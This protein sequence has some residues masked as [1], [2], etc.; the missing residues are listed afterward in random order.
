MALQAKSHVP[1]PAHVVPLSFSHHLTPSVHAC[2]RH[3]SAHTLLF[4]L[5]PVSTFCVDKQ[6]WHQWA[7]LVALPTATPAVLVVQAPL[8]HQPPLLGLTPLRAL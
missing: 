6:T 7:Q 8:G 2:H 1:K 5:Q 3:F 4:P